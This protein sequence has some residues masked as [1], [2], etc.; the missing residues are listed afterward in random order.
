MT[1]LNEFDTMELELYRIA[2]EESM[3]EQSAKVAVVHGEQ[4]FELNEA[5]RAVTDLE[6]QL[7]AAKEHFRT[8]RP[9]F[10]RAMDAALGVT[11]ALPD[12]SKV[13]P[14][15]LRFGPMQT[16]LN[17]GRNLLG[18]ID[19]DNVAHVYA[20][21]GEHEPGGPDT[22]CSEGVRCMRR[23]LTCNLRVG[24]PKLS[25][26]SVQPA[27]SEAERVPRTRQS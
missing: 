14:A 27:E 3:V 23:C 10:D 21:T 5:W 19:K 4:G 9:K 11:V 6:D 24:W 2:A 26:L 16:A 15:V 17:L 18:I 25:E 8:V 12:G 1:N 13:V 22:D 20:C 7:S